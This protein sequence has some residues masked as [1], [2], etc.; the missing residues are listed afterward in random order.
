MIHPSAIISPEA[1]IHPT[2][3]IGPFCI[4]DAGVTI[5][6]H[7]EIE[8]HVWITSQAIIGS[9]NF[10]GYGSV[11]GASPQD[12]T[13]DTTIRSNVILGD[14][15]TLRENVTIHR[16]TGE[17][18]STIMGNHNLLMVNS[19]LA[20]DVTMGDHNV[21]ANNVM[22]AGHI[23]MGNHTFLGGGAGFH[24]FIHIG[25]YAAVQGNSSITKDLPPYCMA[26][27]QNNLHGLNNVGLKRNGFDIAERKEIKSIYNT[28]FC[29][30]LGLREAIKEIEQRQLSKAGLRLLNAAQNPSRKGLMT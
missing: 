13:F 25:S 16:S 2:V 7:C 4:I 1:N 18:K 12:T 28:F 26:H 14:H 10:I 24:Q 17:N 6:E 20:H 19:H 8:A 30:D 22:L 5:G 9:H 23:T 3:N 27:G 11:I 29:S 15:N 21:L